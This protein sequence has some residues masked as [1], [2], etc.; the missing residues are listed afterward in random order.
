MESLDNI[1]ITNNWLPLEVIIIILLITIYCLT[2]FIAKID[3]LYKQNSR[4][5]KSHLNYKTNH[6]LVQA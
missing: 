4:Q 5:K 6:I 1:I 3:T 2:Y